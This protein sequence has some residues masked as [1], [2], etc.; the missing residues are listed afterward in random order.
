[1]YRE[2]CIADFLHSAFIQ[3]QMRHHGYQLQRAGNR[4]YSHQREDAGSHLWSVD[5]VDCYD[6]QC[7]T[8]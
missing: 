3:I 5:R 8:R 1:M 6:L 2:S 4:H 7:S